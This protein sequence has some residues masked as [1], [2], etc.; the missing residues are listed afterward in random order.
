MADSGT[1][2]VQVHEPKGKNEAEPKNLSMDSVKLTI[3]KDSEE[4]TGDP[5]YTFTLK[6]SGKAVLQFRKAGYF[7]YQFHL[8][9][10]KG[11][12]V[13][14]D[15]QDGIDGPRMETGVTQIKVQDGSV[16]T[17]VLNFEIAPT[18]EFVL[19]PGHDFHGELVF[20]KA[21]F[22][23][24]SDRYGIGDSNLHFSTVFTVFDFAQGNRAQWVRGRGKQNGS[25]A[26]DWPF[27]SSGWCKMSDELVGTTKPAFEDEKRG[28][29]TFH[30]L[31]PNDDT[32][33]SITHVYEYLQAAGKDRPQ[34]VKE[35][36]FFSHS[37]EYGPSLMNTFEGDQDLVT[38]LIPNENMGDERNPEDHDA[39]AFKDF[40]KALA[41]LLD[42]DNLTYTDAG[43]QWSKDVIDKV[44]ARADAHKDQDN[45]FR[46]A[47][48]PDAHLH[49]WG[50]TAQRRFRLLLLNA[51]KP[52]KDDR[53]LDQWTEH[54]GFKPPLVPNGP[55]GEDP[56]AREIIPGYFPPFCSSF[57]NTRSGARRSYLEWACRFNYMYLLSCA[58][59]LPVWGAPPGLGADEKEVNAWGW[60]FVPQ[61][62]IEHK[63]KICGS[64][65]IPFTVDHTPEKY[66]YSNEFNLLKDKERFPQGFE[67][68]EDGYMKYVYPMKP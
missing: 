40:P 21:A 32:S 9:I 41:T 60:M 53:K 51:A 22:T 19:V 48:A 28:K 56:T 65:I 2:S 13:T 24:M 8:Q 43:T 6:A 15:K 18:L 3:G 59:G 54:P 63:K 52:G 67:F 66:S 29:E 12:T 20:R 35:L 4:K 17:N 14:F 61:T 25:G 39:R 36:S 64:G 46:A 31:S 57:P 10:D 37:F 68:D 30:F 58:T 23:R 44:H 42:S 7:P 45:N 11:F 33:I 38:H 62:L 16:A 49:V 26:G 5:P 55:A 47:F 27:W 34:T 50:C 1:L